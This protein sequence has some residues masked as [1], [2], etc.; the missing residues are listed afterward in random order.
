MQRPVLSNFLISLGFVALIFSCARASAPAISTYIA[1]A[2]IAG[3]IVCATPLVLSLLF[4]LRSWRRIACLFLILAFAA[5]LLAGAIG[6]AAVP[7]W[8]P[9]RGWFIAAA[10]FWAFLVALH[11]S[12]AGIVTLS[13]VAIFASLGAGAAIIGILGLNE[14]VSVN[15]VELAAAIFTVTVAAGFS[16]GAGVA[17]DFIKF[18][19]NGAKWRAAAIA[20]GHSGV[21]TSAF[22]LLISLMAMC[23]LSYQLNFGAVTWDFVWIGVAGAAFS[24]TAG[25]FAVCGGLALS[26]GTELIAARE[27]LRRRMF[28]AG[29]RPLRMVLPPATA[30]AIVAVTMVLAVLL[31]VEV[32]IVYAPTQFLLSALIWAVAAV[33]FVS[34]RSAFFIVLL[35]FAGSAMAD[36]LFAALGIPISSLNVRILSFILVALTLAQLTLSWR[37]A[38]DCWRGA[39]DIAEHSLSDGAGR[40]A[41]NTGVTIAT[42]FTASQIFQWTAGAV[43]IAYVA[44]VSFFCIALSPAFMTALS[45]RRT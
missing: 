28:R 15:R 24:T 7:A 39:R 6:L 33:I 21:A 35:L 8:F 40:F 32:G 2:I 36:L 4:P 31:I 23:F 9:P 37:E 20:A 10:G 5:W 41:L 38:R 27:N 17:A 16:V 19:T 44:A 29:W 45:L 26:Q 34:V 11:F 42:L 14:L 1:D 30:I 22:S 12:I 13:L 43:T 18:F 3:A 25:L